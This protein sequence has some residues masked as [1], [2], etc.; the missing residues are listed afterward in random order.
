MVESR[1]AGV[2]RRVTGSPDASGW[3]HFATEVV[4]FNGRVPTRRD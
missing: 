2:S 4:K 1:L 3:S